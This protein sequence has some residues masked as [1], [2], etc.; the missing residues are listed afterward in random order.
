[1]DLDPLLIQIAD[2][3]GLGQNISQ[4][5]SRILRHLNVVLEEMDPMA[6]WRC[7]IVDFSKTVKANKNKVVIQGANIFKP[8]ICNFVNDE[9]AE[10][11]L[12]YRELTNF[13][14]EHAAYGTGTNDSPEIYTIGGGYIYI[15][16]GIMAGDTTISGQVRRRLTQNDVSQLPANMLI[17]GTV[18]RLAKK[19]SPESTHAWNGWNLAKEKVIRA[20]KKHTGEERDVQPVDPVIARNIVYINSV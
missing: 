17:D 3:A 11:P 6:V 16:P 10:Y 4:H 18:K 2:E 5:K 8:I 15:G 1:M 20:A 19:G 9:G 12:T 14:E 13:W 7:A